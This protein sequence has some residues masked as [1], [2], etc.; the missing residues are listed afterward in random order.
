MWVVPW[1][2]SAVSLFLA[3]A[4]VGLVLIRWLWPSRAPAPVGEFAWAEDGDVPR[5]RRLPWPAS[6]SGATV[7]AV[8]WRWAGMAVGAV[9][10]VVAVATGE[11]A[12]GAMLAWPVFGLGVLVGTLAGELAVPA[13]TG[14]VRR[15]EL[16]VRRVL[17]YVPRPLGALVCVAATA[18]CALAT[19]TTT[20]V[21]GGWSATDR[22]IVCV[23]GEATYT[24]GPWPGTH[25]TVPVL[26][27]VVV[28]LVLAGL[29][30][31]RVV[32]RPRLTDVV[33]VD[34]VSRR[35]SAE[36]VTAAAGVLVLTPVMGVA[37][38]AGTAMSASGAGCGEP[39]GALTSPVLSGLFVV[40]FLATA[41]C[42]GFLLLPSTRSADRRP[43]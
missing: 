34:D 7:R 12:R 28:G 25:Y 31:R 38:T 40:A 24:S 22:D 3:L 6:G 21:S 1:V 17:D 18:L 29:V 35:R 8:R 5:P 16:R 26:S 14:P 33:G 10:A 2:A 4:T 39:L 20:G 15:A 11:S 19:A 32:R 36:V 42:G 23:V 27:V 30:L 41:W 13:P 43:A 37:A 9:G